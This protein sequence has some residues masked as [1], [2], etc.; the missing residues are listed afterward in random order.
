MAAVPLVCVR[1]TRGLWFCVS[2]G[3]SLRRRSPLT[4]ALVGLNK[5]ALRFDSQRLRDDSS[6]SRLC[7]AACRC[8]ALIHTHTH[9]SK[10]IGVRSTFSALGFLVSCERTPQPRFATES[11]HA[12]ACF[13]AQELCSVAPPP[14]LFPSASD[15]SWTSDESVRT[16]FHLSGF[17]NCVPPVWKYATNPADWP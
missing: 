3:R 14:C 2:V 15:P 12:T 17:L 10:E 8:L 1:G 6:H 11:Q 7:V 4:L 5:S 16:Q 13:F 9:T